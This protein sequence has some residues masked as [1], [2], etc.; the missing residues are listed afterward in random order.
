MS[1][2]F[3]PHSIISYANIIYSGGSFRTFSFKTSISI[4]SRYGINTDPGYLSCIRIIYLS[5][6]F[7]S[8]P[9]LHIFSPVTVSYASSKFMNTTL[10][11]FCPSRGTL[12][13]MTFSRFL[14]TIGSSMFCRQP[15]GMWSE[16]MTQF[17]SQYSK[18]MQ[19][20]KFQ[21][22]FHLLLHV[23]HFSSLCVICLFLCH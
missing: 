14:L 6:Q 19:T 4:R 3:S 18:C 15:A 7:L 10:V 5:D 9:H 13:V 12:A 1:T 2:T 22:I 21:L 16:V 23:F 17:N 20:A 11:S 8:L